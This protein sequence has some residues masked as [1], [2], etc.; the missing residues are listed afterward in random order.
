MKFLAYAFAAAMLVATPALAED[1]H[2][3]IKN[4]TSTEL[5]ELYVSHVGTN[6]WEENILSG[7][8]G[9]GE[10]LPVD[11]TDGRTTCN[12]DIK[13]VF[14]DGGT[15]EFRGQ[16]LCTTDTFTVHD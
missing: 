6:S 7:G 4:N 5:T 16:N 1:L 14:S 8:V 15:A 2:I 13:A 11:I 3:T 9:S 12:Y 10:E